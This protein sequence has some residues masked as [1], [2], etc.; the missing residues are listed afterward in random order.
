MEESIKRRGSYLDSDIVIEIA[1]KKAPLTP[2]DS[3]SLAQPTYSPNVTIDANDLA[4]LTLSF[5]R[6]DCEVIESISRNSHKMLMRGPFAN[7]PS[8]LETTEGRYPTIGSLHIGTSETPTDKEGALAS[9]RQSR[10]EG[11]RKSCCCALF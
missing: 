10:V 2:Y 7:K 3:R 9:R 5:D 6:S 8:S 1:C 11:E 4:D